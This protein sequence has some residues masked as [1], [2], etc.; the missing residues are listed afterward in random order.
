M[1][2]G[3]TT[4]PTVA[5]LWWYDTTA[6][7]AMAA[8]HDVLVREATPRHATVDVVR[9]AD[10]VLADPSGERA[11]TGEVIAAMRRCRLIQQ[12][13]VGVDSIDLAA[14]ADRGITVA[15][16]SGS[17]SR[18]VAEW[19]LM[20]TLTLLRDAHRTHAVM[21]DGDWPNAA[22]GRELAGR[23]VGL[24]G[25]GGTARAVTDLVG[26]FGTDVLFHH[27]RDDPDPP[28][29]ARQVPLDELL[30]RSDV[31]SLHV[32]LTPA[33]RGLLDADRL[34]TM[35]PDAVLVNSSRGAVVDEAALERWL[36]AAPRRR[37]ALDVFDTE[38]LPPGSPLRRSP[39]VLL[40]PH[41]AARTSDARHRR[42]EV[43]AENLR[44]ALSGRDILHLVDTAGGSP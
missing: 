40:S 41:T 21:T 38:P 33:T 15:N 30:R 12:P 4:V 7:R 44:R 19:V 5:S 37:A 23:T 31:L 25:M 10:V 17:N 32:P 24:I 14:A 34:E 20:A 9:D 1:S 36:A 39:Q 3:R 6:V 42:D 26:A 28:A 35:K 2:G 8:P 16:T 13:S 18:A 43:V 22:P 27:H 11:L 29:G